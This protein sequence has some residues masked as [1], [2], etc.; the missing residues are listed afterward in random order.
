MRRV[1][2]SQEGSLEGIQDWPFRR[3]K[4]H[5]VQVALDDG[6]YAELQ[7][8]PD[9]VVESGHE[10]LNLLQDAKYPILGHVEFNL[11]DC[12]V[13]VFEEAV[14]ANSHECDSHLSNY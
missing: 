1:Y 7:I 10:V 4:V 5:F 2:P 3:H 14:F 9:F 11:V 8:L 12:F 13:V 6:V